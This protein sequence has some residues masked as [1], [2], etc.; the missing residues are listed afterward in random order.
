MFAQVGEP[1][2]NGGWTPHLHIQLILDLLALNETF[3]GVAKPSDSAFWRAICPNPAW[4]LK[5]RTCEEL[6]GQSL[7]A[8]L[9]SRRQQLLG[10]SLSLSYKEPLHIVRGYRQFH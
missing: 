7:P 8:Q 5:G 2:E 1:N 4:L 6:D 9:Q 3:P 10:S